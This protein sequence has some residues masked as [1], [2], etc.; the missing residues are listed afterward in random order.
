MRG[1]GVSYHA[2]IRG[3]C[4][5]TGSIVDSGVRRV[6]WVARQWLVRDSV[7]FITIAVVA[8]FAAHAI[9]SVSTQ[10]QEAIQQTLTLLAAAGVVVAGIVLSFA[11]RLEGDA[12][13]LR[14]ASGLLVYGVAVLPVGVVPAEQAGRI[15]L[16]VAMLCLSAAVGLFAVALL[17]RGEPIYAW[18]AAAAAVALSLLYSASAGLWPVLLPSEAQFEIAYWTVLASWVLVAVALLIRGVRQHNVLLRRVGLG[19]AVIVAAHLSRLG[20]DIAGEPILAGSG[21]R[22]LGVVVVLGGVAPYTVAK[23]GRQRERDRAAA[24]ELEA[25]RAAEREAAERRH[26]MR[27][28]IVGLSGAAR[29]LADG[30]AD[31]ELTEAMRAEL[32]RLRVLLD[33]PQEDVLPDRGGGYSVRPV[34]RSLVMLHRSGGADIDLDVPADLR[35]AGSGL[36]LSQAV[37]NLLVNCARH[38]AGSPVRV[39][40]RAI[41]AGLRI[42]V[43]DRGPGTAAGTGLLATDNGRRCSSVE[44]SGLGL[45][46]S[47]ELIRAQ[48]GDLWLESNVDG[49]PGCTAVITLPSPALEPV[50][51][52]PIPIQQARSCQIRLEAG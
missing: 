3:G 10:T 18:P 32:D 22:L 29:L 24:T 23:L 8:L 38:A 26:E 43:S 50:A 51:I 31:A 27:N 5:F 41:P 20:P 46:I 37:V 47:R 11:A 35:A 28:A 16:L 9:S 19:S 40:A 4:S 33:G 12:P 36:A 2:Q 49:T 15:W 1:K 6:R 21:V 13:A 17:R 14:I 48:G 34:L 42:E 44:G 30:T 39:A 25:S 45:S 7:A 52:Q